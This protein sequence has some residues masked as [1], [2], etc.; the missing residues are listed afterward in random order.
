MRTREVKAALEEVSFPFLFVF[1][2]R[3]FFNCSLRV[4]FTKTEGF[5]IDCFLRELLGKMCM[6]ELIILRYHFTRMPRYGDVSSL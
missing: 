4:M 2:L 1:R 3:F 5:F 6:R